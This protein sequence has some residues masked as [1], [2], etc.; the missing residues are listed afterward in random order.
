LGGTLRIAALPSFK[1][2]M[3]R[4]LNWL[5][6]KTQKSSVEVKLLVEATADSIK[7]MK[8]DVVIVAV[9][10]EPI[11]PDIPGIKKSLVVWAGDVD[12][13]KTPI[14][15]Q[16]LVVGAGLTGCETALHL[17][18]Q[19]RKV[20]IIDMIDEQEIAKDTS[21]VNRIKLIELLH[22]GDVEFKTEVK[23]QEIT[24]KGVI[25]TD[26]KGNRFGILADTVILSLGLKPLEATV[27]ALQGLAREVYVI[28]DC[29]NPRNLMAAIHDAF[30]IAAEL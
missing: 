15:K 29:S 10:A 20:K 7:D 21:F 23:L 25:V 1:I 6:K 19:G 3:K 17:A 8:P 16:V 27:K 26:K 22:Q 4:Y 30:T 5:I 12:I 24:D 28:G 13:G 18:Q 14:G 11:M 9:G 2:D